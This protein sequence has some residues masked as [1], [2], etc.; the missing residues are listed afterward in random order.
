MALTLTRRDVD[1]FTA[2]QHALLCPFQASNVEDWCRAVLRRA[3]ALFRADR[4]LMLVWAG[5]QPHYVS[6]SIDRET[7]SAAERSIA[8]L[9]PA[10][11]RFP[12]PVEDRAWNA[13]RVCPVEIWN[14]ESAARLMGIA[15]ERLPA[16]KE[17]IRAAGIACGVAASISVGRGQAVLGV[18]WSEHARASLDEDAAFELTQMVLPVFKAGARAVITAVDRPRRVAR[19]LD[20]LGES[21]LV[22]DAT[23]HELHRTTRLSDTL[24]ADP[25]REFILREMRALAESL[26]PQLA[27]HQDRAHAPVGT[28]DVVTAAGRYHVRGAYGGAGQFGPEPIVLVALDKVP[29]ELPTA[30]QLTA[31]HGLTP[32]QAEIAVLLAR[33]LSNREIAAHLSLSQS[34]VRHHAEWVFTKLGVHSRKALGLTLIGRAEDQPG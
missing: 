13:G 23:G 28:L 7:L 4:S 15:P 19:V 34:T 27:D 18:C 29:R 12:D 1:A 25:E 9:K 33:G 8:R 20:A 26:R 5:G 30:D 32:R 16:C 10:A 22:C 2:L 31:R 21:L 14:V 3:E 6:D 24:G 17:A 11:L